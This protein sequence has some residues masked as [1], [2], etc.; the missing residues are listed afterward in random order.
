MRDVTYIPG[1]NHSITVQY[2]KGHF[3]VTFIDGV[4]GHFPEPKEQ[5][6]PGKG[7]PRQWVKGI[8][9]EVAEWWFANGQPWEQGIIIEPKA[10]PKP[11]AKP[12]AKKKVVEE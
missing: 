8:P 11:K 6:K 4:G 12:R 2:A 5:E 9:D 3:N 7:I 10:A 1:K